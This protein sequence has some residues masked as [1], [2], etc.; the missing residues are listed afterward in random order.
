[1]TMKGRRYALLLGLGLLLLF[2]LTARQTFA[3][4]GEPVDSI[5][6]DRESL[7][8]VRGA[9][10]THRDYTVHEIKTDS[11]LIREYVSP[12]GIVFAIA[13]NGVAY[14]DLT[15]LLGS[16]AGEYQDALRQTPRIKGR[17]QLQVKTNRVVVEKWGHIRDL[18]GRAYAPDLIPP[19]V[20][21]DAIK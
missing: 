10:T 4:L 5:E 2:L 18:K 19:G 1:M 16:Y 13:W 12:A 21:I 20:S 7:T 17:R 9:M 8:A 6:S 14:P 11:T 15:E 3:A